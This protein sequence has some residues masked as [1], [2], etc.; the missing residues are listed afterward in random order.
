MAKSM[1]LHARHYA[2]N[3]PIAVTVAHGRITSVGTS[4]QK[5]NVWIAPAFFDPQ[6]NGCLGISFNSPALTPSQVRTVADVCR[7]HGIGAFA[8][9]LVTNSFE[10]LHHGFTTLARAL[11]T[12]PEL[13]RMMPC[14]HLEGP[15]LSGEDGPRGAHPQE[16]TRDPNW[17]E[18]RRWQDAA[19]GR[20]RMVTLAPERPG[21]LALIE[22][23]TAANVVVAIGHTAATGQQIRDAVAA[24]ARTSTHLGNGCHAV[25]PRHDN[26]IWEQLACDDLWASIITDGYHLPPALVKCFS[27]MK[28]LDR[29][30]ITSDVGS[31]AGM[32]PGRYRE[33][34]TDLEVLP[35]GKIVVAGTPFLAGSGHFTDSCVANVIRMTGMSLKDAVDLASVQ[36][37]RLLGLPVTR[38]EAG[39]P[40]S[41]VLF[42][43]KPGGEI[44]VREVF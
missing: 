24:G 31:L 7:R 3:E 19:G 18:F 5:P 23:L 36:P 1:T 4:D 6:I 13:A 26:Y 2:T 17:D 15:Y 22:Q 41:L 30:L 35:S 14:F 28:G 27:R 21:A 16:H 38:I 37:R 44:A 25:L 43:W 39:A 32:P 33:W 20:I 11:D 10:A 40:A 12:D 34:G 42:D 8:P 29:L 9:T